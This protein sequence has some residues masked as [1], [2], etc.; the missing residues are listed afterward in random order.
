[1]KGML[2]QFLRRSGQDKVFILVENEQT[3]I[4]Y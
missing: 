3:N 1:M 2:Q 4:K